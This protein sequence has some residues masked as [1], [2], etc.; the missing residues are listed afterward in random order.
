MQLS[1]RMPS[2]RQ[3]NRQLDIKILIM[4]L[5]A[6]GNFRRFLAKDEV[7]QIKCY[8][9]CQITFRKGCLAFTRNNVGDTHK[10][11]I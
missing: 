7:S 1:N 10:D 5:E 9:S 6:L 3:K 8:F 11:R 4:I 2:D